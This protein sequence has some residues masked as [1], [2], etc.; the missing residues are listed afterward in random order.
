MVGKQ[1]FFLL[2]SILSGII[3]LGINIKFFEHFASLSY[4]ISIILL[5]G[6]F[7]LGKTVSG[8]TSWYNLGGVSLQPSELSKIGTALMIASYI[9]KFQ[10]DLRKSENTFKNFLI[11]I[12]SNIFNCT[13]TRPR[14]SFSFFCIFF[15]AFREGLSINFLIIFVISLFL[16]LISLSFE[17]TT[18]IA[19]IGIIILFTFFILKRLSNKIR[20][21]PFILVFVASV[22]FS[23][24]VDYI[25][26]NLFEQRHRDRINIVIGKEVD[27]RGIGYNINQSKIAIGSGGLIGKGFL[28]GTQTKGDFVPEQQTDLSL[29]LLGRNGAS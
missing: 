29:A 9:S 25:F 6:L 1:L 28:K 24:S 11:S 16:F 27:S 26:N 3:I 20:V 13:T 2:T 15:S 14:I 10:S 7:V 19:I 18:S 8:A 5:A 12:Y 23:F 22:G 21:W 4:L 17:F